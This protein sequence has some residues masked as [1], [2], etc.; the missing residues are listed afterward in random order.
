M[1][2]ETRMSSDTSVFMIHL[3]INND[4]FCLSN[5][6]KNVWFVVIISIHSHSKK[7]FLGIGVLLECLVK[8]K[9]GIG[10]G[11]L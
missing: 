7:N 4:L 6:V 2:Q 9:N 1:L 8:A 3:L 10:W 11:R 5:A